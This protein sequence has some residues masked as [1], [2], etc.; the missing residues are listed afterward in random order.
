VL[1]YW[2]D[3][4][5]MQVGGG[6]RYELS[7]VLIETAS[8]MLGGPANGGLAPALGALALLL[9]LLAL[10]QLWR[11]GDDL[12]LFFAVVLFL[13][14]SALL[15]MVRHDVL[16]V[17]YF[18]V[19][20]SFFL[21]LLALLFARLARAGRLG[22]WA[23]ALL[24][25]AFLGGNAW[26]TTRLLREGRGQYMAALQYMDSHSSGEIITVGSDHDLRNGVLV[27]FYAGFLPPGRVRYVLQTERVVPDWL[28]LHRIGA[29]G[30]PPESLQGPGR[31]PYRLTREFP[32]SALSGWHWMLYRRV[33]VESASSG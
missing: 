12:W 7:Q 11:R 28:L 21:L 25:L 26:H 27:D 19:G 22:R 16:F 9:A 8:Y 5:H 4:R 2:I 17:R 29:R 24:I 31:C 18:L 32:Y 14:P 10:R 20:A 1:L 23:A 30:A 15:L 33:V 3:V 6:P 13:S